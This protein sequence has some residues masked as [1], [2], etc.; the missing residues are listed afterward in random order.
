MHRPMSNA[1]SHDIFGLRLYTLYCIYRQVYKS[2]FTT[3]K[4]TSCKLIVTVFLVNE[5]LL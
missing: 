4:Y 3:D 1:Q 2:A 5:I